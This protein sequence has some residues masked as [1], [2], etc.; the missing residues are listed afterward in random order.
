LLFPFFLSKKKLQT[1]SKVFFFVKGVPPR[2]DQPPPFPPP[3]LPL[4]K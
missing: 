4:I 1:F 2:L 3:P